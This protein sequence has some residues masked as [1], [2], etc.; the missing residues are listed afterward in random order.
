M[1]V[2]VR[3]RRFTRLGLSREPYANARTVRAVVRRAFAAV[4]LP[5]YTPH[6]GERRPHATVCNDHPP[7]SRVIEW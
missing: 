6:S 7:T 2:G 5:E 4:G 1:K 3:E